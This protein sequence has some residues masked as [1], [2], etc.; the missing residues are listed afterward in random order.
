MT[1]DSDRAAT[2]I[3]LTLTDLCS[4]IEDVREGFATLASVD[5]CTLTE[6]AAQSLAAAFDDVYLLLSFLLIDGTNAEQANRQRIALAAFVNAFRV[7]DHNER[8]AKMFKAFIMGA[9]ALGISPKPR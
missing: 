2:D 7:T 5:Q 8:E 6:R 9:T 3:M 4:R 1:N